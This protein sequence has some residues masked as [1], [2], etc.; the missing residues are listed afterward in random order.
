MFPSKLITGAIL[1]AASALC[2]A[3]QVPDHDTPATSAPVP[4]APPQPAQVVVPPV[5][6]EG[7]QP[8]VPSATPQAI[9]PQ[10]D[11]ETFLLLREAARQDDAAK[12]NAL[13][14]RLPGYAIPSYV[15]YYRLKPR[16]REAPQEEIRAFLR[17]WDGTAIAD[18]LRN[19]WLLELGR[20]RDWPAFDRELP[21]FVKNDDYQVRCYALLSRL[22]KGEKV[23]RDARALLTMPSGYGEACNALL[24]QLAQA[25]Q[26]TQADLLTQLRLAGEM[27]ATGPARRAAQL[28]GASETRAVQAVDL[29]ALALARGVGKTPA[30]HQIYLVAV[31]RMARTS[32]KLADL[33][34]K[35][36]GPKLSAEERA[37]GWSNIALAA[38]IALSPEAWDDWKKAAGAPLS[39][40][41]LQWKTRIALR[42]GDW[43]TVRTTIEAMPAPLR[44]DP[45][46]VYWRGRAL[47]AQGER[48]DA[49]D[50]FRRIADQNSFYG[51]LAME[52]LGQQVTIPP[53]AR[54]PTPAEMAQVAANP[55]FQRAL[56][57]YALRLRFEGTR[58]WNWGLRGYNERQLLA[59]AEFARRNN[60]LDRM[61]NTSERTRT[62]FDYTQRF[63]DPH[64]DIMHPT[65]Q[66][67]GLDKAWAYGL[68]RQESRFISD[69]QSG[70]GASGLMQVMPSTGKWVAAKIGLTEFVHGMLNDLKTNITLGANYMSMV[71]ANAEGSQV[72]ATAAYNAG[73]GRARAW[74]GTLA[75]PME[76]AIF[77]ETIPFTETRN[78]VRNVMSNA[79]NYAALFDKRP[80]SLKA[81]LGTIT[82]RG[83]NNL[84][85]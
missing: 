62:E 78:Y 24:V 29:P 43:K 79:T 39:A 4:A 76:G 46:W 35:K 27:N 59:A 13:A 60:I 73:P 75:A 25:G 83:Q 67:L 33:A 56:K 72:L 70:V 81:R 66:G 19:D 8:A 36:N 74:R 55:D 37:I 20:R 42:Q 22:A 69:A 54:P 53:A 2:L 85:P 84:L 65:A 1:A 40:D 82:P 63:P 71:L 68:I 48:E 49:Q 47:L 12:A 11:D 52:E 45:A 38:S 31:G 6:G 34:L 28:L 14:S 30:E 77:V 51:Q 15:D 61:I 23:A 18:R 26:F 80:Q 41:Q 17:R 9:N 57:F 50:L 21:L 10:A 16:L 5:A 64:D 3:G 58:E 44:D 32:L 7:A